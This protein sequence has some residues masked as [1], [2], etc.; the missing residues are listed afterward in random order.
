MAAE[1]LERG[2]AALRRLAEQA[3]KAKQKGQRAAPASGEAQKLIHE[4]QVHQIELEVQNEELLATRQRVEELLARYTALYD[5]APVGYCTLDPRGRILELNL[6]A[7]RFLGKNRGELVGKLLASHLDHLALAEHKAALARLFAHDDPLSWDLALSDGRTLRVDAVAEPGGKSCFAALVDVSASLAAERERERGRQR[8]GEMSQRLVAVQEDERRRLSAELHDHTSGNL[9]ALD[10]LLRTLAGQLARAAPKDGDSTA[11]IGNVQELLRTTAAEI[12]AVCSDLRPP[13]L[14][15]AGLLPALE[16]YAKRFSERYGIAV[17]IE[18]KGKPA[19]LQ[20]TLESTLFRIAQE[21][22][23]N[24]AKHSGAKM[25][26]VS[27]HFSVQRTALEISDD[28]CG[29]DPGAATAGQGLSIMRERAE[30][31]GGVCSIVSKPRHGTKIRVE[32]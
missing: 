5:F 7:A 4:L 31:G 20:P 29:F 6:T 21:A 24:C 10:L 23:T 3:L 16:S 8:L 32:F 27:L 13:L 9:A 15:Y 22:L 18:L 26:V 12:R 30:F 11:T 17:R 1:K 25:V 2:R 28:G 19:R 14:D